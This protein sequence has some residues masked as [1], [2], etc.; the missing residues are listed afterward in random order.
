MKKTIIMAFALSSVYMNVQCMGE[1]QGVIKKY[2]EGKKNS[3]Q[4]QRGASAPLIA[5]IER[6]IDG[7]NR[8]NNNCPGPCLDLEC[9]DPNKIVCR[10]AVCC[11]W[12]I[13]CDAEKAQGCANCC[14]QT[15][16]CVCAAVALAGCI[17]GCVYFVRWTKSC[18][19]GF[20]NPDCY[21]YDTSSQS[22]SQSYSHSQNYTSNSHSQS[23]TYMTQ[24]VT[25]LV[26]ESK[27]MK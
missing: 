26:N 17:T 13:R 25:A 9:G 8:A 4:S 12:D 27:K 14:S 11:L 1:Q 22:Y 19:S 24:L 10:S 18:D 5:D 7:G 21:D 23:Y 16:C 6:G 20:Y 2:L 15:S 3:R